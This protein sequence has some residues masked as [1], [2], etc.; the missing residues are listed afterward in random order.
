M[1]KIDRFLLAII[2]GIVVLVVVAL[3]L[4]LT[5]SAQGYLPETSPGNIAHNYVFAIKQR[6]DERAYGY[7][8]PDL[9]GYPPDV[10]AF[11]A[12]IS[13]RYSWQFNHENATISV[14][15]ER[16]N[17]D[18]ATVKLVESRFYENGL[19]S[20]GENRVPINM[21]LRQQGGTW[22]LVSAESYWAACW[23]ESR[24]CK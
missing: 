17:A 13:T 2:A 14:D 11:T 16:I 4:A 12:D 20:N 8:S 3:A 18:R 7:L 1:K 15:S 10:D 22:R 6:D 19:F 5:R 23:N 21:T 9:S 24:P